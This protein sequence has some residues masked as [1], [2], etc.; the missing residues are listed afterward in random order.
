MIRTQRNGNRGSQKSHRKCS[1]CCCKYDSGAWMALPSIAVDEYPADAFGPAQRNVWRK[2]RC[3]NS[4]VI[5]FL[6]PEWAYFAASCVLIASLVRYFSS[7][8]AVAK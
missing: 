1:K 6:D 3:G 4:L 8:S 7:K 2:C 5:D